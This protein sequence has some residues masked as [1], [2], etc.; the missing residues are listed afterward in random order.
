[1]QH[2]P[3][4]TFYLI[5]TAV[6][7]FIMWLGYRL[8]CRWHP[9]YSSGRIRF[10]Y[11]G[12][13]LASL[14]FIPVIRYMQPARESM[15][16]TMQ[17][18]T[19]GVYSWLVGLV[20]LLLVMA[21]LYIVRFIGKA[22][23]LSGPS[24]G[25][26]KMNRRDFLGAAVAAAPTAAWA[27]SGGGIIIGDYYIKANR[28]TLSYPHLPAELEGYT[29]AQLSDAHIGTFFGMDKLDRVLTMV[30]KEKPDLFVLTGD[31]FDDLNL[32][33]ES[34]ERLNRF[35]VTVPQGTYFCWGNH[36]YFRN[37]S[38]IREAFK[39][40]PITVLANSSVKLTGGERPL[41]LL[42]V[43]Y[44]WAKQKTDQQAMRDSSLNA[45]LAGVPDKAFRV[46]LAH[47][48]DFL[49]NGFAHQIDLTLSGHTHGGQVAL[50]GRSLLPIQ[51]KYMRGLYQQGG[52]YGYVNV[53]A[54][55]WLPFRLGCAAEVN[56]VTLTAQ[57]P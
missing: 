43:D 17:A 21:G 31:I 50:F 29:I 34:M 52:S 28:Q 37:I 42:G 26:P 35:A 13:S 22:A 49:D 40:S 47:H 39:T 20:V 54:G 2:S 7:L 12:L 24:T 27:V 33:P 30:E 41:Y 57:R 3:S 8:L 5:V 1:M 55:H 23:A 14:A 48:P 53:G 4:L 10:I 16:M 45:A 15:N 56:F 18:I 9:F 32:L 38:V 6:M 19:Y 46:L 51:Y 25:G 44:P 11:W 36:E